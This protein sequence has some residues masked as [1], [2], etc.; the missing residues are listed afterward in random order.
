MKKGIKILFIA[1]A[2]FVLVTSSLTAQEVKKSSVPAYLLSIFIGFG[3]G[4]FYAGSSAATTFLLLDIG[5]TALTVAGAVYMINATANLDISGIATGTLMMYAGVG[6]S[7]VIGIIEIIS[8]ITEVDKKRSEGLI[9]R[10]E[11]KI[12]STADGMA[13]S[14]S[15]KY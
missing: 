7:A 8:V 6:I 3:T 13:V 5:T 2:I 10:F 1:T 12:E 4:H 14:V 11:P 15:Y 9:A